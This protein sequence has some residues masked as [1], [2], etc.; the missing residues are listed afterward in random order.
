MKEIPPQIQNQLA[1]FQQLQQNLQVIATQRLQL[2]ARL[3]EID[4]TLNEFE[5]LKEDATIYR[6]IGNLLVKVEDKAA[7]KKELEEQ[8]ETL[9]IRVKTL[10]KQEKSLGDRYE[11]LQAQLSQVL[12]GGS[13]VSEGETQSQ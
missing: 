8:K 4:A 12:G 1:Q 3:R 11:R 6:N 13:V 9:S 2:E 5:R 10:E 7:L